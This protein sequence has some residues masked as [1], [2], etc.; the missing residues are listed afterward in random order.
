[1][2]HLLTSPP[3]LAAPRDEG[4]FIINTDASDQALV[5]VLEQEQDI[6]VKV[7]AYASRALSDAERRYCITR[8]EL[9]GVVYALKKFRQ[10]LLEGL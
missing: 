4:T 6:E 5:A 9:L 2:K 3:V 7:L 1:M 10:H 8:K